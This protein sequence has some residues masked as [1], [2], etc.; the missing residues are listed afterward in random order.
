MKSARGWAS[1]LSQ[2]EV[3]NHVDEDDFISF[4]QQDSIIH[5]IVAPTTNG[6]RDAELAY[7]HGKWHR[8]GADGW[9][10][11]FATRVGTFHCTIKHNKAAPRSASPSS[12]VEM[13]LWVVAAEE[14]EQTEQQQLQN[15]KIKIIFLCRLGNYMSRCIQQLQLDFIIGCGRDRTGWLAAKY[16]ST[17][18]MGTTWQPGKKL[19][20]SLSE[21]SWRLLPLCAKNPIQNVHVQHK[22]S[23][24]NK[25]S[26]N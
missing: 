12:N 5:P 19:I 18:T 9:K 15:W 10:Q 3:Y 8:R 24:E 11:G 14:Q 17:Q 6:Q 23:I 7:H 25:C 13:L 22:K 4:L 21:Q 2:D 26:L 1:P 20:F 16:I